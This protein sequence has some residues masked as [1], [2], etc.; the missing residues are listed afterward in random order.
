MNTNT[1]LADDSCMRD[2]V[3]IGREDRKVRG[4]GIYMR[5]RDTAAGN[6]AST[7]Y[8]GVGLCAKIHDKFRVIERSPIGRFMRSSFYPH[9]ERIN[10]IDDVNKNIARNNYLFPIITN[11]VKTGNCLVG[12]LFFRV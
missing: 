9:A 3:C 4:R 12:Q 1:T 2:A 11:K 10:F 6:R 7:F 5:T 8:S